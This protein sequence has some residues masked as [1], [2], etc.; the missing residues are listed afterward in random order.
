MTTF[1]KCIH[2]GSLTDHGIV[3]HQGI[4]FEPLRNTAT[5]NGKSVHLTNQQ[6]MIAML[7]AKHPEGVLKDRFLYEMYG[8]DSR[9][10]S[11]LNLLRVQI[12]SVNRALKE[13]GLNIR[14]KV[15]RGSTGIYRMTIN[16]L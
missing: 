1:R 10:S 15:G 9:P 8:D 2:C 14:A 13:I 3:E 5:R 16:E 6:M 7:A 4:R 12:S 11:A